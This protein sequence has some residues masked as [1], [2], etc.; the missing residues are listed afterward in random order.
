VAG[1]TK[2]LRFFEPAE[3]LLRR[4]SGSSDGF[5]SLVG[6]KSA[7]GSGKF[8]D[9][10]DPYLLSAFVTRSLLG[11]AVDFRFERLLLPDLPLRSFGVDSLLSCGGADERSSSAER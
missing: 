11:V 5:S 6:S 2:W 4:C 10:S 9:S 3:S 1:E 8:S 7:G